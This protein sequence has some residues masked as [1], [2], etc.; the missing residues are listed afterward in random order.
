MPSIPWSRRANPG[1][2][3]RLSMGGHR[4][5]ASPGCRFMFTAGDTLVALQGPTPIAFVPADEAFAPL[6]YPRFASCLSR[7]ETCIAVGAIADTRPIGLALASYGSSFPSRLLS[8]NVEPDWRQR[9]IGS[10]LLA[11]CESGLA[12]RGARLVMAI[13]SSRTALRAAFERTLAAAAWGP[14]D[15]VGWR[16]TAAC[17][18]MLEAVAAWRALRKLLNARHYAFPRWREMQ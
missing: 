18:S 6:T 1:R 11:T 4:P 7:P 16:I 3:F 10:A 13:H 14:S 15:H 2:G 5:H 17:G 9:G 8:L 12:T